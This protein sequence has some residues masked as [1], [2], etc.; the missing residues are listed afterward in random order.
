MQHFLTGFYYVRFQFVDF[1]LIHVFSGKFYIG[2]KLKP[3]LAGGA[4]FKYQSWWPSLPCVAEFI[5]NF[6]ISKISLVVPKPQLFPLK[7]FFDGFIV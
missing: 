2:V 7:E 5:T 6:K 1:F 3:I 4:K